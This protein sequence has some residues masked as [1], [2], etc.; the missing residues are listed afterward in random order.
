MREL[1]PF[2][3]A[4]DLSLWPSPFDASISKR[5]LQKWYFHVRS[6]IRLL[7]EGDQDNNRLET[8]G[9]REVHVN[10]TP[11]D[12]DFLGGSV[13]C[14][15]D[16]DEITGRGGWSDTMERITGS[17][18]LEPPKEP[19][20]RVTTLI[21]KH[22]EQFDP[23]TALMM[24]KTGRSVVYS[25]FPDRNAANSGTWMHAVLEFL[26]NGYQIAAGEMQGELDAAVNIVSQMGDVEVY[27]T[28]WCI[29]APDEDVAGSIDMVL[30]RRDSAVFYLVDWKRSEKLEDKCNGLGKTMKSP[31]ESVADCQ[32]QHYRL[33]L[34]IYKWILEK[35]YGVQIHGM[36]VVCIHPRYLPGGFVD[37]VPNM[38]GL[39]SE[40]TQCRRNEKTAHGPDQDAAVAQESFREDEVQARASPREALSPT[41]RFPVVLPSQPSV[42]ESMADLEAMIEDLVDDQDNG[43]PNHA[44]KSR[45]VVFY[46]EQTHTPADF[47][48]CFGGLIPFCQIPWT[49]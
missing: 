39:V 20:F 21:H 23:Q 5:K 29:Y 32:G 3:E 37:D 38:Q 10:V 40:L 4:V 2:H 44:K 22:S 31:L 15:M 13:D 14:E 48:I 46:L 28:E 25:H 24:M 35:Y 17:V 11:P 9:Q 33:Q 27:R 12:L 16:V 8:T 42:V 43:A 34:N 18:L 1:I 6:A 45:N 47:K 7:R 36:K 30:K 26:F 49:T 19:V 41:E